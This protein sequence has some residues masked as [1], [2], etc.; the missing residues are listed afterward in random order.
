MARPQLTVLVGAGGAIDLGAPTT[1][2]LTEDVVAHLSEG[3]GCLSRTVMTDD[4]HD[5]DAVWTRGKLLAGRLINKARCYYG[6]KF[7]FENLLNIFEVLATV[8]CC[9]ARGKTAEA[10]LLEP[11]A[12]VKEFHDGMFTKSAAHEVHRAIHAA[13]A[14][15][16]ENDRLQAR[17][18]WSAFQRFWMDLAGQTELASVTLNYD[19]LIEQALNA[20]P[21]TQGFSPID[22]EDLWRFD[23]RPCCRTPTL[24]HLHGSIHFGYRHSTVNPN[25]LRWMYSY[26]DLFWYADP[27]Q[28]LLSWGSS[29]PENQTQAGRTSFGGPII[30]GLQKPDELLIEPF[31]TYYCRLGRQLAEVPR[32]LV[33]GYGF[34]D[35]HVN[36]LLIG[37]R[38]RHGDELRIAV[39]TKFDPIKMHGLWADARP[40]EHAMTAM[41]SRQWDPFD[42]LTSTRDYPWSSKDGLVRVYYCGFERILDSGG[43]KLLEFLLT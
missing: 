19:T 3:W 27:A 24:M 25:P 20:G 26:K 14:K 32:L 18:L 33:I 36:Q 38:R 22:G 9:H 42:T 39:I 7:S 23:D 11:M 12:W 34:S 5:R 8:E 15:A 1:S 17:P 35:P 16:S 21:E 30:S 37:M 28:A 41:W 6:D 2:K 43:Q 4:Q 13:V 29:T 10:L 40:D 31:S